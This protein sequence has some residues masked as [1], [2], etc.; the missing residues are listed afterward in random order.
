MPPKINILNPFL[1]ILSYTFLVWTGAPSQGNRFLS[2]P[3]SIE[4]SL[5]GTGPKSL[6]P[7]CVGR[8]A[9]GLC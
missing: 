3:M 1:P 5:L 7:Q 2:I 8:E 9:K 6:S 4:S